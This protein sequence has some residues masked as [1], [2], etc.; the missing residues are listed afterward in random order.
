MAKL[1]SP[2]SLQHMVRTWR[3]SP[4]RTRN[5]LINTARSRPIF[6]YAPLH[7]AIRE[8]LVL[9]VPYH[10]VV[11][12]VR[13]AEK[14][15]DYAKILLEILPMIRR[16]LDGVSPDFFQDVAPR[17]YSLA[18]DIIIPFHP[19]VIYGIAGQLTLPWCI[20]WRKNPLSGKPLSL[21][22]TLVDEILMEDPDLETATFQLLDFSI[23]KDEQDRQLSIRD[24]REIPRLSIT[25]RDEMLGTWA[26]GF[27]LAQAHMAGMKDE[28][29]DDQPEQRTADGQ[30]DLFE[31][32]G[33]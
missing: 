9:G 11:E 22:M 1:T 13:R 27:R 6:S 28:P 29:R 25:E 23:P 2:P 21:F 20:F 14:R 24:G 4:E 18:S 8:L 16:H 32:F 30:G 31:R 26:E 3:D 10:Q 33:S 17:S 12:F 7:V 5:V 15:A 19:P